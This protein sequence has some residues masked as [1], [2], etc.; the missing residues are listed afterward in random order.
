V[1]LVGRQLAIMRLLWKREEMTV[2][3]LQEAFDSQSR[4]AYSTVATVVSRME[5]KGLVTHRTKNR[6]Y[7]YRAA[8]TEDSAGQSMVGEFVDRIFGGKPSELVNHLLDSNQ[9]DL[10]ELQRI[11]TM[12]SEHEKKLKQKGGA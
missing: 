9:V 6:V 5:K 4:L 2:A 1:K 12:V 7:Y 8:V 3:E 11:K 10:K